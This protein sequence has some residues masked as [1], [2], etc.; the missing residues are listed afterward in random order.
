MFNIDNKNL[1]LIIIGVILI[2]I[3]IVYFVYFFIFSKN[4]EKFVVNT[5]Y[6]A[7]L[8]SF[9]KRPTEDEQALINNIVNDIEICFNQDYKSQLT[10]TNLNTLTTSFINN[11][12][13]NILEGIKNKL[14]YNEILKAR[15]SSL[16]VE[17]TLMSRYYKNVITTLTNAYCLPNN[18]NYDQFLSLYNSELSKIVNHIECLIKKVQFIKRGLLPNE[19]SINKQELFNQVEC[20]QQFIYSGLRNQ[21]ADPIGFY[22]KLY[23]LIINAGNADYNFCMNKAIDYDVNINNPIKNPIK[24]NC[25]DLTSSFIAPYPAINPNGCIIGTDCVN[26]TPIPRVQTIPSM[27]MDYNTPV[28]T[29]PT[30]S[31]TSTDTSSPSGIPVITPTIKPTIK[32]TEIPLPTQRII[33]QTTQDPEYA[34]ILAKEYQLLSGQPVQVNNLGGMNESP[35]SL[36]TMDANL[37]ILSG[38]PEQVNNLGGMNESPTSLPSMNLFKVKPVLMDDLSGMNESINFPISLQVLNTPSTN[39]QMNFNPT[40]PSTQNITM[41]K[42]YKTTHSSLPFSFKIK[43]N[44]ND[45][46]IM[47]M[48]TNDFD[49]FAEYQSTHPKINLLSAKGPNNFFIPNIWI[50][51]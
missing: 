51:E 44:K 23:D 39:N 3:I 28:P 36:P 33:P 12:R 34:K 10:I 37:E 38:Q 48:N 14:Y 46:D 7:I 15:N 50:E 27:I 20:I 16:N 47:P 35:T 22:E 40:I 4:K 8:N 18:K 24:G 41:T 11:W 25:K 30:N 21:M 13:D 19:I 31:I 5:S 2:V 49:N 43:N 42:P 32:P 26:F 45:N 6:Q 9:N 1:L 17:E 29:N